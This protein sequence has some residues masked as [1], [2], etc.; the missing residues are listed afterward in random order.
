VSIRSRKLTRQN[1]EIKVFADRVTLR[2]S[3]NNLIDNND[4]QEWD[5]SNTKD[6][7]DLI[8]TYSPTVRYMMVNPYFYPIIYSKCLTCAALLVI[9]DTIQ[10][11]VGIE[12]SC[13]EV[14]YHIT[15]PLYSYGINNHRTTS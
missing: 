3:D 9:L 15:I 2:I 13:D 11:M 14:I 8:I 7:Y 6:D 12:G 10:Y 5:Q 4:W 1:K